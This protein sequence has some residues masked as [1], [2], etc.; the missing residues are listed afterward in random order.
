MDGRPTQ[1]S[2]AVVVVNDNLVQREAL[3]QALQRAQYR[4]LACHSAA[5][6]L[7]A[8][9]PSD[10]PALILTDLHLPVI[11]GWR[12]CRLLRSPAYQWLNA[13]PILV[14]S[15][16]YHSEE[17]AR[18]S[19][20]AGANGFLNLPAA[21]EAVVA[22]V[23]ALLTDGGRPARPLALV[24]SADAA[25]REQLGPALT[26]DGYAVAVAGSLAEA[27]TRWRQDTL[28]LLVIR[29]DLPDGTAGD[30]LAAHHGGQLSGLCVVVAS[31]TSDERALAWSEQGAAAVL[32]PPVAAA[33]VVA[34]AAKLRA[35]QAWLQVEQ[36][37]RSRTTELVESER[38]FGALSEDA[39]AC[40]TTMLPDGTLTYLN[41]AAAALIGARAEELVGRRLGELCPPD[42]YELLR[43]A[44]DRLTPEHPSTTHEQEHVAADGRHWW[45]QWTN[46]A[47][48]NEQG[49]LVQYQS[50]GVDIT[51]RR[52]SEE[53]LQ[54]QSL[55]LNQIQDMVTVTDLDGTITYVNDAEC[56]LLG[57]SR[58]E[59][60]GQSVDRYGEDTAGGATQRQIIDATL[61]AGEWRGQVVNY[62]ADGRRLVVDCRTRLVVDAAGQPVALCGIAT[63]ITERQRTLERHQV[64][65]AMERL[66][67]EVLQMTRVA[68][69]RRVVAVFEQE[70]RALLPLD[71]CSINLID[72]S[73]DRVRTFG[74]GG[75]KAL[76][77]VSISPI[78][79]ALRQAVETGLPVYRPNRQHPLFSP[80]LPERVNSVIDVPC[81]GG[82]VAFCSTRENAFGEREAGILER[83][84]QVLSV[85]QQRL[86]DLAELAERTEALESEIARRAQMEDSLRA[87]TAR[88]DELVQRIPVG[89]FLLRFGADDTL[90]FEYASPRV[91]EIVGVDVAD[92]LRDSALGFVAAHPDDRDQLLAVTLA[93]GR[94]LTPFRWEGRFTVDGAIRW[95]RIESEPTPLPGGGSRWSGIISDVTERC[96]AEQHQADLLGH[97]QAV[98]AAADELIGSPDLATLC[99][100]AVELARERLGLERCGLFLL[101]GDPPLLRAVAGTDPEGRT[102]A[103]GTWTM[104]VE[105]PLL[106]FVSAPPGGGTRWRID[107]DAPLRYRGAVVGC[108]DHATTL[109]HTGRQKVG[110]LVNDNLFSGAPLDET[111]QEAVALYGSLLAHIIERQ[112]ATEQVRASEQRLREVIEGSQDIIYR[113][114]FRTG[115]LDYMSPSVEHVLGHQP[116]E[117]RS[118]DLAA[119]WELFHPD[120]RPALAGFR[121][122]LAA[123]D[124]NGR[125]FLER[126]FR[127]LSA[128]GECRWIHGSYQLTRDAAGEPE[129]VVGTL[130]DITERRHT[131][132]RLQRAT[133]LLDSVREAQSTYI[134]LGDPRATFDALLDSLVRLTDS[135]F[136]FLDEVLYGD[137]EAAY[138]INLALS[139]IAWSPATA[140]LYEQLVARQ[141]EFRDRGWTAGLPMVLGEPLIANEALT[142]PRAGELPPGHPTLQ[143]V[144]CLPLFYGDRLVG[145]ACVANRPGGYSP[146]MVEELSPF[147]SACS[148]IIQATRLHA[149]ERD[150]AAALRESE[151]KYREL[152]ENANSA[153]MRMT[154]DGTVTYFNEYAQAFFGYAADDIVGRNVTGTIIPVTTSRGDDLSN[155]VANVARCPTA[156][157]TH[158]NENVRRNGERVWMA[159]TNKAL[160]DD[161]GDLTEI[162]CIGNDLT[163]RRQAEAA[164]R[165]SEESYRALVGGLPDTVC[166]F[167]RHGRHLFVSGNVQ[168]LTGL[169][170]S[171][172]LGRTHRELGFPGHLCEF[173]EATIRRAFDT[174][175][176]L[177]TEFTYSAKGGQVTLDWRL[178]PERD[179]Q[180]QVRSVLSISRDITEH[181]RIE[182]DYQTL[183]REM[184]EGFALHEVICDGSG[185]PIDYRFLA[186]NPAFERIT[187]LAAEEVVGRTVREALP[188]VEEHWIGIYGRVALT[189]EPAFFDSAA[190]GLG[191]CFEVTAFR[192]APGQFACIFTDI[193]ERKQAERE[194]ERLHS[195]L[196]QAHKMESVGRLAAGVAHDLNNLLVPILGYTEL[197]VNEVTPEDP[198]HTDLE[199]ILRAANRAGDLTRQ[200]LAFGRKQILELCRL[201]LRQVVRNFQKLLRRTLREDIAIDVVLGD[202]PA[203]VMA[204]AGQ[205]EQVLMNLAVNA[206]D[207]MPDGGTLRIEVHGAP[208]GSAAADAWTEIVV[209]DTGIGIA[210]E[211][212]EHLFEPFFTTKDLGKGTGLGLATVH[213]IIEQH[214]GTVTVDS[215][216][217]RGTVFH[218]RLP[219]VAPA[220]DTGPAEP[221]VN[222]AEAATGEAIVVVDDDPGILQLAERVLTGCGY[223]VTT[224]AGGENCLALLADLARPVDLLLTD[225]VMP[226]MTGKELHQRIATQRPAMRVLFMSGH[227]DD[228]ISRRGILDPGVQFLQKPFTPQVLAQKVRQALDSP[229]GGPASAAA[230]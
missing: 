172:Y 107:R 223:R 37:L 76:Y 60:V 11:D 33:G 136:G 40:V 74:A 177:E 61:A 10:T 202:E 73:A 132:H 144:M 118:R 5:A 102:T 110:T 226:G 154:P 101:E 68:D 230:E 28:A 153:I 63:D 44:L 81:A 225:V 227:D 64:E 62:A 80:S 99:R 206:Q 193:T 229:P 115:A 197:L 192:P 89:V 215:A 35:E 176:P 191:K 87:S 174:G 156:Y 6:A 152:V 135:E 183:F 213:G 114:S 22:R 49:Q 113:Q 198:R 162:L 124:D 14:T 88:Y 216:V 15:A 53:R 43:A 203:T 26:G 31:P 36:Q 188:G 148:S 185:T 24:V 214:G 4:V 94:S 147:L 104:A 72:W 145:V 151:G 143:A 168:D 178:V 146:E 210:P 71:C 23:D 205:L 27:R 86:S 224:A 160:Y 211:I 116:E 19:A 219:Q 189:G 149:S 186:V 82:T 184:L 117:L 170:A 57:R 207:A 173:L 52:H 209:A 196:L 16:T 126:E 93:A 134:A 85:A 105:P 21:D 199:Q 129:Y 190:E 70:A 92:L 161:A 125:H 150:A 221:T 13:V 41:S 208:V 38:R 59:I 78:H 20:D 218:C 163:A 120:D 181:R 67:G 50:A 83:F 51:E 204:D 122:E 25:W 137:D 100:R 112:R 96:V 65:L 157:S 95:V 123:H 195:Q 66:R 8:M 194:R 98:L 164:L 84:A 12:F 91:A 103:D 187:G 133:A 111:R 56:R 58:E 79:P 75:P 127:M 155:L 90:A 180:G 97:L 212:R 138:Q 17:A 142:D 69:W 39:T 46:R 106:E 222:L 220:K 54:L 131:E 182:Q 42:D 169:A 139:N 166:R 201:D 108:G 32:A 3:A 158:E 200:L 130:K 140:A 45:M 7:S 2:G 121:E 141:L 159:W 217:G 30:C 47:V 48:Y 34:C 29:D 119:Q 77:E 128:T 1:R 165:E 109:L 9:D 55:V 228:V 175:T 167:D 18:L 171:Q 179:A